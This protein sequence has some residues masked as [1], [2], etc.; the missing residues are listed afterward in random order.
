[1]SYNLFLDEVRAGKVKEVETIDGGG[2]KELLKDL[3]PLENAE[4]A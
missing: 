4:I 1:M 2:L 3:R